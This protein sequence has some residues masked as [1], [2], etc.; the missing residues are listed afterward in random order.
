MNKKDKIIP[1][2]E[3]VNALAKH[4][5]L[6]LSEAAAVAYRDKDYLKSA[7]MSWSFIEQYYLPTTIM[8]VAKGLKVPMPS[9]IAKA[10]VGVVIK[11]YLLITHD[12]ELYDKLE[13]ARKLRNKITHEIYAKKNLELVDSA[14]KESAKFNMALIV[15][16]FD[17]E[18]GDVPIPSLLI[19]QK[20]RES[21]RNEQKKRLAEMMGEIGKKSLQ[22]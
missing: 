12:K 22:K 3:A 9:D 14:Y 8:N 6:Q 2:D 13:K 5:E 19:W 1:S 7:V 16:M 15:D 20:A 11:F 21:L 18:L 17:R 10:H 4:F